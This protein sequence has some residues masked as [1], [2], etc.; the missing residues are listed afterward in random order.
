M[1]KAE[2]SAGA[3]RPAADGY[4]VDHSSAEQL[5]RSFESFT[6]VQIREALEFE[7]FT[8]ALRLLAR[9]SKQTE[10]YRE[11]KHHA[12]VNEL[13]YYRSRGNRPSAHREYERYLAYMQIKDFIHWSKKGARLTA[14]QRDDLT[15]TFYAP[16]YRAEM[17]KLSARSW[18]PSQG[19]H[20]GYGEDAGKELNKD[21]RRDVSK[22]VRRDEGQEKSRESANEPARDTREVA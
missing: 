15:K 12:M 22:D 6:T 1:P 10:P 19:Y 17:A 4:P 20:D 8:E 18:S 14:P 5:A 2:K 3:T 7:P 11:L 21:A 13:G 16:M 9:F